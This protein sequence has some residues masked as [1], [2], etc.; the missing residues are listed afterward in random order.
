MSGFPLRRKA[1]L[2]A[3][4]L[5]A[6]GLVAE[7]Q[8]PAA[9]AP[10]EQMT[11]ASPDR[12]P[13]PI[14]AKGRKKIGL[15]FEGGGALGFA[16]IGV[17]KWMEQHHIPVDYISGT[18]MGG[19]V[20]GLYASGLSPD[21][22]DD[23]VERIDWGAVLSGQVPFQSLSYR[24]KEDK[25]A[26]A[27][28][29]QFGLKGGFSLPGG[30]NSGAAVNLLFD[31]T[32]LPY[33]DLKS[34]DDLP[35]P[36][37]CVATELNTGQAHVFDD[38]PLPR[39][40][41][42][43]MSIPGVFA[44]V[45]VGND[46]YAD[47]A[48]V[49]N[50]PV[51]VARS[52]GAEVIISSYL[53]VG[54]PKPGS[55]D[56]LVGVAGRNVSIM[57][58]AN[59]V[60][61][62]KH[63]DIVISSDVG[64]FGA[65]EFSRSSEIIPVGEKAAELESSA[66]EKYALND[67]DWERYLAERQAR[68]R[69]RVPQPQFIEVLGLSGVQQKEVDAQFEK[70]VGQPI[71]SGKIEKSIADLQGTGLYSTI[72][73]NIVE[74]G[75]KTGLLVRAV[76]K[77]Y[78]PPF[79]NFSMPILA[80]DSNDIQLGVALRA[81]FYNLMGPGSEVRLDGAVGQTAGLSGELFKPVKPGSKVFV[82]PHAYISHQTNPYYQGD[83]QLDQYKERRNG[84]GV[85]LG[86]LFNARTELRVGEDVQ[87]FSEHRKIGTPVG[88]EFSI[89]PFV[90]KVRFQYFGQNDFM[91][92]S[93]GSL[94]SATYNYYTSQPFGVGGYSQMSGRLEHFIPVRGRGILF[95][96]GQGGTSFGATNLGLAGL[97]MG[98]P[99]RLSAYAR[100]ELLGTDYFLGQTGY[101]QRLAK[102]NPVI[103]DGIYIGAAYEIGKM[104]GGNAQTPALPNDGA[105]FAVVKTL[106][107]PVYGGIS[108][109]DSDHRKWFFGLG[110]VF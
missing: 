47:G 92:P 68:R 94:V 102:L 83:Q 107:G 46:L 72:N 5:W 28:R 61:S 4:V 90:S 84:L 31:R 3:V 18:S 86:Y 40:L 108:I 39:A 10:N 35:I 25:L 38:G 57:V 91:I 81:T 20:G 80:D 13:P 52:M 36:F 14:S 55:L 49:D 53:D 37:R 97:A 50:L 77:D 33:W 110:R 101:L 105:A 16:H 8:Q 29:L 26:F 17:I 89:V 1:V 23:F 58:A 104:Y 82:A 78:G 12:V 44:P 109:G 24:R 67:A 42:S 66:L 48:A 65:L 79:M 19:L 6:F 60:N 30:L 96:A 62:L 22:I 74:K 51:D 98:G 63:S 27:N 100:N 64:K 54:P 73:Y 71:D 45:R 93:R 11:A 70:Y 41:R 99:L 56:S 76:A 9:V 95:A 85:D 7:S 87:W 59:E 103:A 15:V 75:G 43:T 2:V 21:E 69:T 88:N 32:M 34:F 106:L